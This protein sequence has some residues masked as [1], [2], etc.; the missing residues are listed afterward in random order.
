MPT[1]GPSPFP[2]TIPAQNGYGFASP[3]PA[4]PEPGY[5]VTL[6]EREQERIRRY[7]EA[8]RFYEGK[9]HAPSQELNPDQEDPP[10][11]WNYVR[12]FV[13]T[14]RYFLVGKG[15]QNKVAD[16]LI[17]LTRPY[18][19]RK[20]REN[21]REGL[22]YDIATNGGV[23]GDVFVL[24]GYTPPTEF[25]RRIH[26]FTKG[27]T[28]ITL[29]AS[30]RCFPTWDPMNMQVMTSV[31][32]ETYYYPRVSGA[33]G[34]APAPMQRH[35]QTISKD[36]IIEQ[37]HG[38][39][40]VIKKNILGEIPVV[41]I[42]NA[43][44]PHEYYGVSDIVDLIRVNED[45]NRQTTEVSN[46]IAAN[47]QPTV[48]LFGAKT[49]SPDR[50][51]GTIWSGLPFDAKID[52]LRLGME[53]IGAATTYI[54]LVKKTLHEISSIPEAALGGQ[55]AISNT[56]G[57]A[58]TLLFQPLIMLTA[59]K[60]AQ[61]EPG[62][63]K[64]NYF[65]LRIGQLIGEIELP[66]DLCS[67]G[68]RIVEVET[69]NEITTWDPDTEAYITTP[70]RKKK[71]FRIDPQTLTF[72][73]PKEVLIK[74]LMDYGVGVR[75]G[76]LPF[77]EVKKLAG[78][79]KKSFWAAG[80]TAAAEEPEPGVEP[81]K[82][83]VNE[84]PK[85]PE[86]VVVVTTYINPITGAV[87]KELRE[88]KTLIPTDCCS[89]KYL[90]PYETDVD[91]NDVLP[92]D[93]ALEAQLFQMWKELE[94]VDSQWL[95]ENTPRVAP[96][97]KEINARKALQEAK[98]RQQEQKDKDAEMKMKHQELAAKTSN[99]TKVPGKGG[100]PTDANKALGLCQWHWSGRASEW[101]SLFSVPLPSAPSSPAPRIRNGS[102][103]R[104]ALVWRQLP[105]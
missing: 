90:D 68:G 88:S 57:V 4:T 50:L 52:V 16:P 103:E 60:R 11:T 56:S 67:C 101:N 104:I 72:L 32:I 66:H 25:E 23:T 53:D 99:L 64:I 17:D 15:F 81:V 19:D 91:F 42:K 7:A 37:V 38:G 77:E 47:G 83:S 71:C 63:E 29:L 55:M 45:L 84:F 102:M 1:R 94:M 20:W 34:A 33:I 30:E 10:N 28:T 31:R 92:K 51:P 65:I 22:T 80:V 100:N 40:P 97:A 54:E 39:E 35:T 13:D 73:T 69:G 12:K 27:R 14:A 79:A 86:Q 87:E 9:H 105:K 98:D 5:F 95:Q 44:I 74:V 96:Y 62:F 36:V 89:P 24:V 6:Q 18:I 59:A 21:N 61:Y 48:V 58:L 2:M 8:W 78:E 26:P 85:E 76:D 82:V 41:H 3:A 93:D 70:E 75:E 46:T 49:K 43:S